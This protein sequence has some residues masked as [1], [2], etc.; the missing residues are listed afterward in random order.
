MGHPAYHCDTGPQEH[1]L[2]MYRREYLSSSPRSTGAHRLALAQELVDDIELGRLSPENLLL[3]AARLARLVS[4]ERISK[5]INY[6][7]MGYVSGDPVSLE[8]MTATGRYTDAA[9]QI[10][11]WAPFAQ[12]EAYIAVNQTQSNSS[13]SPMFT[14]P[15]PVQ[16][17]MSSLPASGA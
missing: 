17:R 3:K 9:K 2:C 6:E 7:L 12:I 16:T 10:G 4:D 13:G 1:I 11:Y 15:Y 14:S 5:W 8:W